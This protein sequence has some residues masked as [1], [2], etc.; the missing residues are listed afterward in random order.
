MD[1]FRHGL[2]TKMVAIFM[3]VIL[4]FDMLDHLSNQLSAQIQPSSEYALYDA[5]DQQ[6]EEDNSFTSLKRTTSIKKIRIRQ[7]HYTHDVWY[8][9]LKST[10]QRCPIIEQAGDLL[11]ETITLR[12]LFCVFRL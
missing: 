12:T 5:D 2:W 6:A 10:L 1:Y 9:P 3:I 8:K 4:Q 11:S 7:M